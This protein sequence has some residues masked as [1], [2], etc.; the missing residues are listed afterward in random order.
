MKDYGLRVIYLCVKL[1]MRT[2]LVSF[3]CPS[4]PSY[5]SA[6]RTASIEELLQLRQDSKD[7]ETRIRTMS[8]GDCLDCQ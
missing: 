7:Q 1:T 4:H 8:V 6:E 3:T 5:E 2:T